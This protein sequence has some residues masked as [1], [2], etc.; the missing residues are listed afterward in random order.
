MSLDYLQKAGFTETEVK[1]YEFLVQNG[2]ISV[3]Q[4]ISGTKIKRPTVYKA[5]YSLKEKGLVVTADIK[6]KLHARPESPSKLVNVVEQKANE[7]EDIKSKLLA[8]VSSLSA[9]YIHSTEKPVV[10]TY[11]GVAGLKQIYQDTIEVGKTIFALVQTGEVDSELFNWLTST[12]I[13]KRRKARV[14]AKVIVSTGSWAKDYQKKD[15]EELR[16]SVLVPHD[17]FPI[18]HEVDIYGDKIA[19]IHYK[20][21]EPLIGVVIH[22]PA[23]AQTTKAWFDLAWMGAKSHASF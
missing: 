19:F 17:K 21:D 23:I 5:L 9:L 12:Y 22:H 14:H 2:E 3:S 20:K 18:D 6:K 1:V 4:I 7:V 13:R 8:S 11:E 10:R 15:T 16:T